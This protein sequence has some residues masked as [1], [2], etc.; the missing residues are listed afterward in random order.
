MAASGRRVAVVTGGGGGIGTTIVR[1]FAEEGHDVAVVDANAALVEEAVSQTADLAAEVVG[2]S[3]DVA[4]EASVARAVSDIGDRFG[5]MDVLV[6]GAAI[7]ARGDVLTMSLDEWRRTLEV[8]LT[9][10]FLM[11]QV[12]A[13]EMSNGGAIVNIG[14]INA[15]RLAPGI[16]AYGV[17]KAGVAALTQGLAVALAPR[18][19]RVNGIIGG[20]VLTNFS[21][22]RLGIP[23]ERDKVVDSIPLHRLGEARDFAAAAVFLASDA[24]AWVTGAMLPVDGG[25]LALD[26]T[27]APPGR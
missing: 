14:S 3:A 20:H 4:D 16:V 21:K 24:A 22:G 26:P 2:F 11:S 15:N 12:V 1:A 10:T 8:N 27:A 25:W 23:A 5:R 17:S 19:I 7:I 6:N 9:G 18:G 13:R